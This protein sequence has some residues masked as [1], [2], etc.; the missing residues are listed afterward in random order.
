MVFDQ[1]DSKI[2]KL[3]MT[4]KRKKQNKLG[5]KN[6]PRLIVSI[7]KFSSNIAQVAKYIE[8]TLSSETFYR[9]HFIKSHA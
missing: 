9:K 1:R 5:L 6:D 4:N 3:P 7:L 2:M 8:K